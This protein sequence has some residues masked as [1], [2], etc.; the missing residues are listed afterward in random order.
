MRHII[1]LPV[2]TTLLILSFVFGGIAWLYKFKTNDFFKGF[3][4][5][6]TKVIEFTK[7]YDFSSK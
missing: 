5:I 4:Y 3:R 1:V 6:N 7:W 2:F